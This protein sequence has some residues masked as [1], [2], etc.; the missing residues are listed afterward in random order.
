MRAIWRRIESWLQQNAPE[1]LVTL[2][3]G[4]TEEELQEIESE[5]RVALPAPVRDFYRIHNGQSTD[6]YG[7]T[8]TKFLYGWQTPHLKRV[9][10]QWRSWKDVLEKGA[11]R[12][13]HGVPDRGVRDDWWNIKWIPITQN[14]S[15]DHLCL[16]LAPAKGGSVGQIITVWHD[17][18]ERSIRGAS[19]QEWVERFAISLEEGACVYS[20]GYGGLIDAAEAAYYD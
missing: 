10:H 4:A 11:F 16:D 2:Q 17:A 19:F 15:G 5:L 3:P 18:P 14:E 8:A 13:V 9:V 12:G 20:K 6:K 7:F 1:V